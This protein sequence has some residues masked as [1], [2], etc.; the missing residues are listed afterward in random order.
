MTSSS[1]MIGLNIKEVDKALELWM[2]NANPVTADRILS[3]S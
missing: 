1:P 3:T 2:E